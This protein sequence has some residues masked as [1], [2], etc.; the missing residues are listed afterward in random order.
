MDPPDRL[1]PLLGLVIGVIGVALVVAV[2]VPFR[3]DLTRA[4][5]ALLL[6]VPVLGAAL[7]GGRWPAIATG[8]LAGIGFSLGFIPPVG[9]LRV[10][11]PEDTA[12]L[13]VFLVVAIVAGT[14]VAREADR[15]R[16]ARQRAAEINQMYEEYRAVVAEREVL[17]AEAARV[18]LLEEIDRQ[19][20]MLLRSVSHDLRTPLASIRAVATDLRD[21]F[22][23]DERPRNELLDLMAD[24]AERLDR[25]VAN[26]LSLTRIEA[27]AL[28]PDLGA[29][30]LGDLIESTTTATGAPV[31][32]PSADGGRAPD[33][34]LVTADYVQIDQV[35]SNLL[36]NAARH[37]P[38][39]TSVVVRAPGRLTM[40]WPSRSPTPVPAPT[41]PGSTRC[42]SRSAGARPPRRGRSGD[43]QGDRRGPRRY[44]R[45]PWGSRWGCRAPFHP[46]VP[47]DTSVLVVDD[48]SRAPTRPH[49]RARRTVGTGFS[50]RRPD[51]TALD[52]LFSH[53]SD[54]VLLDLGL[55]DIDGVDVCR[56]VRRWSSAPIIV[57]TADGQEDRKIQS[58]DEGADDYV[59]KPFSTPDL[60]A[61]VRGCRSP[62]PRARR[63]R[64]SP[65]PRSRLVAHR[66][67]RPRAGSTTNRS[68]FTESVRPSRPAGSLRRQR[69]DPPPLVAQVWGSS[70]ESNTQPLRTHVKCCA[71]SG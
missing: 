18:H 23:Y 62:P 34:P 48:E 15:R 5:P 33:L 1:R 28:L 65:V 16:V 9:S 47:V 41:P 64:R 55:P 60:L 59:T 25:I 35:L 27:G 4:T 42:S 67:G 11:L 36:E 3:D 52:S 13:G 69:D 50:W 46:R 7:V 17:A 43:L 14:L 57:L 19:R 10:D 8:V 45:G 39:G 71:R 56:H 58:L 40:G 49:D 61:R 26:L 44:D 70:S 6:V 51:R 66:R 22:A 31:P 54:V 38:P 68:T 63:G 37:T 29:T 20:S 30:D 32:R 21:G 2:L 53:E 24:E 12:V